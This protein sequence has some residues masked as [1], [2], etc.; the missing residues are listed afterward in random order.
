MGKFNAV[1]EPCRSLLKR[2]RKRKLA[3]NKGKSG[4]PVSVIRCLETHQKAFD[5][6]PKNLRSKRNTDGSFYRL[7]WSTPEEREAER[8]RL[9]L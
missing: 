3:N 5:S 2:E 8:I 6:I 1:P 9:G 7:G 4:A